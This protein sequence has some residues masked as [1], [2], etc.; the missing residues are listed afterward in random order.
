MTKREEFAK[1][2]G[3]QSGQGYGSA[4]FDCKDSLLKDLD[5]LIADEVKNLAL[6]QISSCKSFY[7]NKGLQLTNEGLKASKQ[8]EDAINK[9]YCE[10][11]DKGY[12]PSECRE[13]LLT[14]VWI[15]ST[16]ENAMRS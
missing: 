4:Q 9:L 8:M 13:M 1:K 14:Q 3:Y 5:V 16:L 2:W 7:H 10:W 11:L 6:P 12:S 15:T